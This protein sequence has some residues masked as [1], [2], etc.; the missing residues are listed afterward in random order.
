MKASTEM[1]QVE[2]IL[3]VYTDG[4]TKA[5]TKGMACDVSTANADAEFVNCDVETD[6]KPLLTALISAFSKLVGRP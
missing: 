3:I 1:K 4:T 5:I 2:Q 6:V